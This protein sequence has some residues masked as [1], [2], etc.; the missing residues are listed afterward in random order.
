MLAGFLASPPVL[1]SYRT[2][3]LNVRINPEFAARL[4]LSYGRAAVPSLQSG[5]TKSDGWEKPR[6]MLS[7]APH[8]RRL[9]R[10][11]AL[12]YARPREC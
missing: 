12:V 8:G 11:D 9:R 3:E 4:E 5:H 10:A 2:S 6:K 1:L 7:E